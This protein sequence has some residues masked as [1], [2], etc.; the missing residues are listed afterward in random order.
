MAA[1]V[2]VLVAAVLVAGR[3]PATSGAGA[4]YPDGGGRSDWSAVTGPGPAASPSSAPRRRAAIR[5]VGSPQR[6]RVPSIGVSAP[7]VA[8]G[9]SADGSQQVPATL[10]EAS[11]WRHGPPPGSPGATVLAGHTAREADGV[12]DDLGELARGDRF[13]I[14][15]SDGT[16][17]YEITRT[18]EVPVEDFADHAAQIYRDTG[19]SGAVLMTCSSW[20]GVDYATTTVVWGRAVASQP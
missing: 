2:V 6:L 7:V 14:K 3:G 15:G 19:P 1:V 20:D 16:V 4:R 9:T 13:R 5:D 17:T 8:L 11:W 10:T 18:R 12:F